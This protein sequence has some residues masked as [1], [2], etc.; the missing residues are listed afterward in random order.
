MV[1]E[2]WFTQDGPLLLLF[3]PIGRKCL[4]SVL[5]QRDGAVVKP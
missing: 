3:V 4:T 2:G 1:S 5:C